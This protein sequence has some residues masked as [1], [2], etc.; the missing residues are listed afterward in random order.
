MEEGELSYTID[1]NVNWNRHCGNTV[2][3]S[4]K[5]ENGATVWSSNSIPGYISPQN[6]NS[7]I[8][9]HSR[10]HS[11]IICNSQDI[12]ATWVS[13]NRWMDKENIAYVCFC[14]YSHIHGGILFSHEKEWNL[15]TCSYLDGFGGHYVRVNRSERDKYCMISH[16]WKY[17][18]I[19]NITKSRFTDKEK[20]LVVTSGYQW[21][22]GSGEG[23][24]RGEGLGSTN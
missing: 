22:K 12:E 7:K 19:V 13:I 2:E 11:S 16:S 23:Q 24:E 5:T 20:K 8:Y 1:E 6:S 14:V 4:Q 10:V 17:N 3:V 18:K 21:G 9:M 15:A